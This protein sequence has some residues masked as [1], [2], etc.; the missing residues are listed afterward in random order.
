MIAFERI[1]HESGSEGGSQEYKH[2]V[3]LLLKNNT[4]LSVVDD[5]YL[6]FLSAAPPRYAS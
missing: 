5:D 6:L 1:K 4:V 3:N 2:S